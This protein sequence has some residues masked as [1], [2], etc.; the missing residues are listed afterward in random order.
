TSR[1]GATAI[2]SY[3]AELRAPVAAVGWATAEQLRA[4][5]ISPRFVSRVPSGVAL[6][7]E[8]QLPRGT[9]LLA[10]SDR[11]TGE[12]PTILR[13]RGAR[14][15]EQIA[16]RTVVGMNGEIDPVRGVIASGAR[17]V[18]VFASPSAGEGFVREIGGRSPVHTRPVASGPTTARTIAELT[19]VSATTPRTP[20][21]LRLVSGV[22]ATSRGS[23][24]KRS[25]PASPAFFSSGCLRRKTTVARVPRIH[26][27]LSPWLCARFAIRR[28][29]SSG[30]PTSASAST[31]HTVIAAWSRARARSTT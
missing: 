14:V 7:R 11:A 9:V 17:P 31:R 29:T 18:V 28:R 27:D 12:L 22:A 4:C 24:K 30:S 15:R 19:G 16:Y 20:D 25:P 10:R 3:H 1:A 26:S 13:G 2:G 8:V 5:G 23:P 21:A 6:G